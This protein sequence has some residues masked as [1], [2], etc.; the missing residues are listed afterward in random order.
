MFTD[1][2]K[3]KIADTVHEVVCEAAGTDGVGCCHLYAVVGAGVLS[4]LT[5]RLHLPQAGTLQLRCDP[6]SE[7]LFTMDGTRGIEGPG[8]EG[9]CW[10]VE[11]PRHA[12]AGRHRVSPGGVTRI[13]LS[14]RHYRA[15]L[16]PEFTASGSLPEWRIEDPPAYV[17]T[18]R[19]PDW[20]FL[21]ATEVATTQLLAQADHFL[22]WVKAAIR[23]IPRWCHPQPQAR[24]VRKRR[25]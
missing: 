25:A 13:D 17:W 5:R 24:K 23:R 14:A 7:W 16:R 8:A 20:L 12:K 9:H 15:L 22:P 3:T 1:R 18:D 4:G 6:A 21:G 11:V 19:P 2:Q 10:V